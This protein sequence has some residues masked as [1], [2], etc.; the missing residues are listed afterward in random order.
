MHAHT[1][2]SHKQQVSDFPHNTG[3]L[4]QRLT[5]MK[6]LEMTSKYA[7]IITCNKNVNT[8]NRALISIVSVAPNCK[9]KEFVTENFW[10]MEHSVTHQ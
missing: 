7:K 4:T 5:I 1:L 8:G 10:A 2:Q 9:E 3:T 6:I